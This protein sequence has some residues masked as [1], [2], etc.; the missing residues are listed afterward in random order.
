[1][2]HM[3]MANAESRVFK[4]YWADG[5]L[6]LA[7]GIALLVT[8]VFWLTGPAVCQS[9][10][11]LIG[12]FLYPILRKKLTEPRLGSVRFSAM[13]R[14]RLRLGHWLMI[15]L[16]VLALGLG[17]GFYLT[18]GD[19]ARDSSLVQNLIPGLPAALIGLMSLGGAAMLGLVR[20]VGYAA[21][22]LS[23]GVGVIVAEAHPGWALLGGG[24]AV[25]ACGLVMMA[26]FMREFPVAMSEMEQE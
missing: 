9:L 23:A 6:D 19:A 11:P 10:A 26:R 14:S 4:G 18:R 16:G 25:T 15:G 5:S 3:A 22:M 21:V 17:V 1:M 7:A 12:L 13:R 8:G 20:F 24:I 2:A